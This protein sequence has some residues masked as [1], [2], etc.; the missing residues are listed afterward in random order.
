MLVQLLA[1]VDV[2]LRKHAGIAEELHALHP[3]MEQ[4]CRELPGAA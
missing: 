4:V 1:V 3:Y 2:S